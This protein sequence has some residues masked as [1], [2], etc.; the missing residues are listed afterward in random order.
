MLFLTIAK[1]LKPYKN[2]GSGN[3]FLVFL[4]K[5]DEIISFPKE[6]QAFA[7]EKHL[8]P[9]NTMV[10]ASKIMIFLI[11]VIFVIFLFFWSLL[12]WEAAALSRRLTT[13][14]RLGGGGSD[15]AAHLRQ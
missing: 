6:K 15:S 13:P 4:I 1:S 10:L 14:P 7:Y 11:F 8:K 3:F 2:N 5:T 9:Y 12:A